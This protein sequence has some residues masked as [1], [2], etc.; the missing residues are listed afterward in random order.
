LS[1]IISTAVVNLVSCLHSMLDIFLS[2][3]QERSF[4]YFAETKTGYTALSL[5]VPQTSVHHTHM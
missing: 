3:K 5:N 2:W 1:L 4:N